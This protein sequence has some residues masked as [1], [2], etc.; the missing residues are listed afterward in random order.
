MSSKLIS[1]PLTVSVSYSPKVLRQRLPGWL[2][3]TWVPTL[4]YL[5]HSLVTNKLALK[6]KH[7]NQVVRSILERL[8]VLFG[9][10]K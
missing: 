8:Q 6:E 9:D 5:E 4:P 1:I 10:L 7:L 2:S 3:I